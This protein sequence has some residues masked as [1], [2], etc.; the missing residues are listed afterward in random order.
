M[1]RDLTKNSAES[2][3]SIEAYLVHL[4]R[5][6]GLPCLKYSNAGVRGYPDRLILLPDGA[7]LWVELK[8]A[9]YKLSRLQVY[10]HRALLRLGHDVRVIDNRVGIDNLI[11]FIRIKYG[12]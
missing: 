2:E 8:S 1:T 6:L 7:V 5:D 4:C 10:R 9:G 3:K 11:T 12:I